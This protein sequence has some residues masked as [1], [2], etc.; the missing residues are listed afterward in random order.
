MNQTIINSINPDNFNLEN[1]SLSDEILISQNEIEITFDPN[2]NYIEYYV[3]NPDGSL[4]YPLNNG[5]PI[6][7]SYSIVSNQLVLNPEFDLTEN[8]FFNGT[9]N[10]FY[11]FL[12]NKIASSFFR[13]YYISEISSDRTEVRLSSTDISTDEIILSTNE[14]ISERETDTSY[15]DFYLN[16]GN[17]Q[18]AIANN[19]TLD[20]D[21]VLIKLYEALP[22]QFQIKTTLWV[23]EQVSNPLAYNIE[24][25]NEPLI[26]DTSIKLK[27]PNL[28][29]NVKDQISNSTPYTDYNSLISTDLTGSLQQ[30][31]SFF[32]DK[33][34]QINVDYTNF[35]NF[36]NFSSAEKRVNNFYYKLGLINT[37]LSSSLSG[38]NQSGVASVSAS[39]AYYTAEINDIIDNFDTYEY[40]LYF[41]SGSGSW[42]KTNSS[43]PFNQASTSS[44]AGLAFYN[45]LTGSAY[46]Y[47]ISNINWRYNSLPEYIKSDSA[48]DPYI[49]F[50]NMVGHFYDE[51]VWIY[52]KDITNKYDGDN[53]INAG[54]S[55]DLIAQQLRDL[56]FNIY[57]NQFSSDNIFT[58]LIGITP[59]GSTFP[60]PFLTSSLP[61]PSGYEYANTLISASNELLAQDDVNKRFYKRFY[62]N[63]PYIYKKKGTVDGLRAL[64]TSYGIPETILRI[65][66]YGGKDKDHTNDWDYWQQQY[67]YKFNTSTTGWVSSSWALNPNWNSAANVPQTVEFRFQTPSLQS[68]I[69]NPNQVLWSLGNGNVRVTLNYTGSGY[70]SGSYSGSIPNPYNQYATLKFIPDGVSSASVYLPFFDGG[71]WSVALTRDTNNFRLY[72]ANKIYSGSDG[73][74][75]GFIASS[76]LSSINTAS[77]VGATASYFP[78]DARQNVSGSSAF[79]GSYQEIRYYSVALNSSSF[80]DYTMNPQAFDSNEV[81]SA[82]DQLAFRA[83]LGGEL[84]TSSISIHPKVTG[85]WVATSS[86]AS[87]SN[88]YISG[89]FGTNSEWVFFD[90][91]IAG[92]KNTVSDKIKPGVMILPSGNT[93]SNQIS[94]QQNS[95]ASSSYSEDIN[96]IEVAFSPQNQINEDIMSSIGYF[97]IG[98]YIGDPRQVSSSDELYPALNALSNN[99]F[100]KYT[101]NYDWTDFIRL[102]KFFDNSLFKVLKDFIPS[103]SSLASGIVIKQHLLE[104]NKYPVPQLTPSASIAF[105]GS[106]ST[107]IPYIVED[108]TL[109]GSIDMAFTTGSTG[110]TFNQFNG[111]TNDWQVT[112]SWTGFTPSPLGNVYFTQSSQEEFFNGELSGSDLL[113]E[114][115]ELNEAN[116]Y[117]NPSTVNVQFDIYEYTLNDDGSSSSTGENTFLALQPNSG[118]LFIYNFFGGPLVPTPTYGNKWM[119]VNKQDING[120][121]V[122]TSL[123][124]ISNINFTTPVNGA[125]TFNIISITERANHFILLL[126]P[127]KINDF[128]VTQGQNAG[129]FVTV[130]EPFNSIFFYNSDD[131]PLFNNALLAKE[132]THFF[133][134]DYSNGALIPTNQQ[135]I[136]S[137]SAVPADV[138]QYN[139]YLKRSTLPRYDGSRLFAQNYNT[140][141]LGDQSYGNDPVINYNG[142][143]AFDVTFVGGTYPEMILGTALNIIRA[144]IFTS[145]SQSTIIDQNNPDI[146][147]FMVDQYLGFSQ[148]SQI[149]S[150]DLSPIKDNNIQ[151]VNGTI[152]WPGNSTYFIPAQQTFGIPTS[153]FN[154]NLSGSLL[155]VADGG[156]VWYNSGQGVGSS[157]DKSAVLYKQVVNDNDQYATGSVFSTVPSASF[158]IS[159]SLNAGN[160]WYVT[161]YTQSNYPLQTF[162]EATETDPLFPFN[163][164][165][166][167][168]HSGEFGLASQG[169]YEIDSVVSL[170]S[171]VGGYDSKL[172]RFKT[173]SGY[174]IPENRPIGKDGL[175]LISSSKSL[176][177]L[178]WKANPFPQP[179]I[180]E[181]RSDYFPSGIGEQGGYVIPD[182]FSNDLKGSLFALQTRGVSPSVNSSGQVVNTVPT[183]TQ[184]GDTT[185][186]GGG[187]GGRS[188]TDPRGQL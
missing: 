105:V 113:V 7:N 163:S 47:D 150:N 152:G 79:T 36:I 100:E 81:N 13:R 118:E 161:L 44:V 20:V 134:V 60:F 179:V 184:G 42:P 168:D 174:Q 158:E 9:Y 138:Q 45:A 51:N 93:L 128:V 46:T 14:F 151:T 64:I 180:F 92:I 120:L 57:E 94:I 98:E 25:I 78:S 169:V 37:Y 103:K 181:F 123:Q 34:I 110:G 40:F 142:N 30:V 167:Y 33:S 99:Y 140:W 132:S 18:L 52:V 65:N 124:E 49:D 102:I 116:V 119:L 149:F 108:Q 4:L 97:N 83:S 89:S 114:N 165:S 3:Y 39:N 74:T 117:K 17:N 59:S 68:G 5:S 157:V 146:F 107:N 12:Y 162:I 104:R 164:G 2:L 143:V 84:Y 111:L 95:F 137:G 31:D 125:K 135:A 29:L 21:T 101:H 155:S 54:I 50:I 62:H 72:A 96:Y 1:Y 145:I 77:W 28:N 35:S 63:L 8:G 87:N 187:Q 115:G 129:I 80:E 133:G 75:I 91:P 76:S 70:A 66:E 121:D 10:T 6:L 11:N 71:W 22:S 69:N 48:N 26:I 159:E 188:G 182:D 90:Q 55:P 24:F 106:G 185:T 131:N 56:G 144:N 109:T 156:I 160:R 173:G 58:S 127:D 147:N 178:V 172:W 23:V 43:P 38:S 112:Q 86:F 67:N 166:S 27:G 153:S 122:T 82:P 177:A 171:L 141:S 41:S 176:G 186:S 154:P 61:T 88:F 19:I 53:R 170:G 130:L 16:F 85:S 126:S 136:L 139:W 32:Q 175:G 148:S 183:S 15:P 73:S